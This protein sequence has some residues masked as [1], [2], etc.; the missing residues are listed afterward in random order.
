MWSTSGLMLANQANRWLEEVFCHQAEFGSILLVDSWTG[1]KLC[2]ENPLLDEYEFEI[3][4]IPAGTTADLQPCDLFLN[5]QL[6]QF[7]RLFNMGISFKPE[8]F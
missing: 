7:I 8:S 2:K 5:M 3:E 4:T 1:Y 6:K